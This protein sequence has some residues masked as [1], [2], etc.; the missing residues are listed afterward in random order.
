MGIRFICDNCLTQLNVKKAQA[1]ARGNCPHCK[2]ELLVPK[3]STV[4]R[5][6]SV[7][8][9]ESVAV[10]APMLDVDQQIDKVGLGGSIKFDEEQTMEG[11]SVP[12]APKKVKTSGSQAPKSTGDSFL[13][14]K[15]QLPSNLGKVDPI[16]EAP[17]KVWYFRSR[18]L[19]EKGPLKAKV[20]Q[21]HL[22]NGDVTI[23]CIVWREDWDEWQPAERV[24]PP[25][26]KKYEQSLANAENGIPEE[27][28]PHSDSQKRKR[29]KW[30]LGMVAIALGLV[31]VGGLV[32]LL[33]KLLSPGT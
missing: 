9:P 7:L 10:S 22:D 28:N 6:D 8:D 20:M 25:L 13:L 24:F 29:L 21:Q 26:V 3:E 17:K 19:G 12:Y 11:F 1:G 16:A 27:L 33:T 15:P 4:G 31:I 18:K 5:S 32:L 23:G 30:A 2:T 14:D